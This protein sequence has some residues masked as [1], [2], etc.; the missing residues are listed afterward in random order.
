MNIFSQ[1]DFVTQ[2]YDDTQLQFICTCVYFF[3]NFHLYYIIFFTR[4]HF[5]TFGDIT[6]DNLSVFQLNAH[7][8]FCEN[9][10]QQK[11]VVV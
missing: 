3:Q 4:T 8:L 9:V 2:Y 7:Y 5:S 6:I 11:E 10:F 1:F